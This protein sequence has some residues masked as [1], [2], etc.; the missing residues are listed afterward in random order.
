MNPDNIRKL[1]S[2]HS[3]LELKLKKGLKEVLPLHSISYYYFLDPTYT[4]LENVDDITPEHTFLYFENQNLIQEEEEAMY[5]KHPQQ[6]FYQYDLKSLDDLEHEGYEDPT[7]S[8]T[9]SVYQRRYNL[10]R[11]KWIVK[12]PLCF[13]NGFIHC[14]L[15]VLDTNVKQLL[16][17]CLVTIMECHLL[18]FYK[19]NGT[20]NDT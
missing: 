9:T 1:H 3:K 17:L 15:P 10:H 4:I 12:D 7:T 5:V 19:M 6:L 18:D 20:R 14:Q 11:E 13:S 16:N 8:T 2:R